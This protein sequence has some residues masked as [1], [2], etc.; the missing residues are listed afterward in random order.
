MPIMNPLL[1]ILQLNY[2]TIPTKIDMCHL[3]VKGTTNLVET[4]TQILNYLHKGHY[5]SFK[6]LTGFQGRI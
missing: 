3:P 4:I 6:F 2:D 1:P 5:S